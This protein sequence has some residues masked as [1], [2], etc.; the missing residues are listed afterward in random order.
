[1][2]FLIDIVYKVPTLLALIDGLAMDTDRGIV[3]ASLQ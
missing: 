1:M 3:L 2:L